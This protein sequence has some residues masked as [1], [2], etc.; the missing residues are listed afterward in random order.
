MKKVTLLIA[1]LFPSLLI[2]AS[3]DPG[4]KRGKP[5]LQSMSALEFSN[6]G[7]LFIGDSRSGTVFAIDL[8]EKQKDSPEKPPSFTDLEK[9]IGD[10]VGAPADDILIH[11]MAVS[12]IS[13]SIYLTVSRGRS[14]WTS[15]WELP[16][17]LADANLLVSINTDGK[18]DIVSM[19]NV[20]HNSATIPNPINDEAEHR[21][22]K[23][24]KL[25][26][27]AITQM[28]F[29]NNKLYVAGL[30][31]EEFASS[32]WVFNYPFKNE[33][34]SSTIEIF[35]GAHGKYET[36]APIRAFLPYNLGSKSHLLARIS[37]HA[38]SNNPH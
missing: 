8:E 31:N 34:K 37:L 26:V 35:H 19:E 13:K 25:R 28:S 6:D 18:I 7:I 4:M 21:W 22:K 5:K 27:D 16:N 32:M 11:D 38:V 10:M 29:D 15:K 3:T 20:K 1:F 12:P 23:G 14:N 33:V 2:L 24:T 36:H 30:S 17:D 9:N